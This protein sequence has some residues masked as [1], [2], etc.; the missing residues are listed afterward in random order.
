MFYLFASLIPIRFYHLIL[1]EIK[2][3]LMVLHLQN[4]SL[5]ESIYLFQLYRIPHLVSFIF[6]SIRSRAIEAP[7][8]LKSAT[9]GLL[10][11]LFT[12]EDQ[13]CYICVPF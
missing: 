2:P 11:Y 4:H 3:I 1:A 12:L 10:L 7:S 6:Q 8:C 5:P 13:G 9:G